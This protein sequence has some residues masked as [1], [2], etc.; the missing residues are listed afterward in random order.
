[1]CERDWCTH[2]RHKAAGFP[3]C[4]K[5]DW[6]SLDLAVCEEA[7]CMGVPKVAHA[8]D[9]TACA[10]RQSGQ[11]C[12]IECQEGFQLLTELR[13]YKGVWLPTE[14]VAFCSAPTEAIGGA[15]SLKHCAG[16]PVGKTCAVVCQPGL[17]PAG[18][19]EC[20][21]GGRWSE[22]SCFDPAEELLHEVL[23]RVEAEGLEDFRDFSEAND[24]EAFEVACAA[25]ERV[26][27]ED[28]KVPISLFSS[29]LTEDSETGRHLYWLEVKVLCSEIQEVKPLVVRDD[30]MPGFEISG[31]REFSDCDK[32]LQQLNRS[33]HTLQAETYRSQLCSRLCK[34]IE[35]M[36]CVPECG[37]SVVGFNLYPK[38]L[39]MQVLEEESIRG[40]NLTSIQ[41]AYLI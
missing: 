41:K 20:L 29:N 1:M 24:A 11:I 26:L 8:K 39:Q 15:I 4:I 30:A 10:N 14:C 17:H 33:I 22:S 25:F 34:E 35:E 6:T 9:T 23:L 36:S 37:D 19:I 28:L 38:S 16:T 7:P 32:K 40:L 21:P 18:R 27:A 31:L 2:P 5:G 3:E 12:P 13:C